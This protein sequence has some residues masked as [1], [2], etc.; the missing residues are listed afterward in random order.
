M[1]L[2]DLDRRY[3]RYL[4]LTFGN[5]WGQ[6]VKLDAQCLRQKMCS[7]NLFRQYIDYGNILRGKPRDSAYSRAKIRLVQLLRVHL[8]NAAPFDVAC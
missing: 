5:F 7:M 8:S 1:T 2:N 3:A 6:V 4:A